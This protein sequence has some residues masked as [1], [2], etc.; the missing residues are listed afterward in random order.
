MK[1]GDYFVTPLCE[2]QI[3]RDGGVAFGL[4]PRSVWSEFAKTD[5]NN[6]VTF[7]LTCFLVQGHGKNILIDAGVGTKLGPDGE[8]LLQIRRTDLMDALLQ[9]AGVSRADI[10]HIILSHLHT[11]AAGGLTELDESRVLVPGFPNATVTVQNGEWERAVHANLRTKQFINKEDFEPLLWHQVLNL[12]DGDTELLPGLHLEVTGGHTKMHQI[13]RINSCGESAIFWGGLVP[14]VHYLDLNTIAA[15][16]LYP[17]R[18]MERKAEILND[19]IEAESIHFLSHDPSFSAIQI[20]G[21]LRGG[22]A[23][24]FEALLT[25]DTGQRI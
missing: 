11:A 2:G 6:M 7:S 1:I 3:L 20:F 5:D 4:L 9:D 21:D 10:D 8:G 14:S 19:A 22:E 17:L 18:S 15:D 13:V 24:S 12:V 23:I 16:D 25:H